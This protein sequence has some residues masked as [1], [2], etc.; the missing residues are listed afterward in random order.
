MFTGLIE[1]IELYS[2]KPTEYGMVYREKNRG[3]TNICSESIEH[4]EYGQFAK[5][6]A[7]RIWK[8]I[9]MG[10]LTKGLLK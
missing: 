1:L 3:N 4:T 10:S 6:T 9:C 2:I 7:C 8:G 5:F